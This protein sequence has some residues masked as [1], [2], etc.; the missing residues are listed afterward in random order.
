MMLALCREEDGLTAAGKRA[1]RFGEHADA[2][3]H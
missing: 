2:R 3:G 1:Q